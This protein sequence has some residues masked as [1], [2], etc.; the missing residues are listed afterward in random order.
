MT[1]KCQVDQCCPTL[2]NDFK[3]LKYLK[4]ILKLVS[5]EIR[6]KIL[7]VLEKGEHCVCEFENHLNSSQSL[8]SHHLK[9][10]K[11]AKLIESRRIKKRN[12]YKLTNLG[13]KVVQN[14]MNLM[15]I[16]DN[17]QNKP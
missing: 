10:L 11:D 6:L 14:L 8:T 12:Y 7:Y 4:K 1:N 17:T 16:I 2:E 3:D 9:D 5:I 15:Q 13:S